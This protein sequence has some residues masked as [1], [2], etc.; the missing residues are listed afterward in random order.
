LELI[1]LNCRALPCA[2]RQTNQQSNIV[3]GCRRP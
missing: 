2:Y 1:S 3:S